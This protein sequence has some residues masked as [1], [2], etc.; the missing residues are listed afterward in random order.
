[1][2]HTPACFARHI[3]TWLM[4]PIYL[5][6][7]VSAIRSGL[8]PVS[9]TL[10]SEHIFTAE[11]VGRVVRDQDT[12]RALYAL[13]SDGAAIVSMDGP[14]M[15]GDSKFGGTNTVRM[16]RALRAAS[17]DSDVKGILVYAD[18]P[19]GHVS[20]TAEVADDIRAI[21]KQ[22]P[23]HVHADDLLASAGYW[24]AS[25]ASQIS[26]NAMGRAGSIGVVAVIEDTS[27]AMEAAGIKVHVRATGPH[28]GAFT[29]GAEVSEEHLD[30]LQNMVDDINSHFLAA[31]KKGRGMT[32]AKVA[33]AADGR[34]FA[35][36]D[37]LAMGLVDKV[38]SFEASLR[39]LKKAW[40][41][42]PA[43]PRTTGRTRA[44][45]LA[46]DLEMLTE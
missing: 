46:V 25:A 30:E 29:P 34:V 11:V 36:T 12:G 21:G 26:I 44:L 33:K 31:V 32:D 20:G 39:D 22:M 42:T 38:Q 1:M 41:T 9:A 18:T 2:E 15:K 14:L 3:G 8:A 28:K 13:T 10:S 23:I 24:I 16:R 4:E 17:A 45:A 6:S 27:K 43:T 5:N 35:A 19:G 7:A 40:A 37:A